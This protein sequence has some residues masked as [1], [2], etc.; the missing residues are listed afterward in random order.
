MLYHKKW[1]SN[2]TVKIQWDNSSWRNVGCKQY[3]NKCEIVRK[4]KVEEGDI[5]LLALSTI[6]AGQRH[7]KGVRM[8]QFLLDLAVRA[9]CVKF[10]PRH[11]ADFKDPT[12]KYTSLC[13]AHFEYS[14]YKHACFIASEK[15]IT[16]R[17]SYVKRTTVIYLGYCCFITDRKDKLDYFHIY[18]TKHSEVTS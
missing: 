7:K 10:V 15:G 6:S 1:H 13:A 4:G 11:Q 17:Q 14:G 3:A 2:F 16:K 18:V 12:S 9:K 5:A 8:H